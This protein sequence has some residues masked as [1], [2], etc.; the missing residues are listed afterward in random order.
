[1]TVLYLNSTIET[2]A[3]VKDP[4]FMIDATTESTAIPALKFKSSQSWPAWT[5]RPT[6][7]MRNECRINDRNKYNVNLRQYTCSFPTCQFDSHHSHI[8]LNDIF[9]NR[10]NC[11][12]SIYKPHKIVS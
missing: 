3:A 4:L 10:K 12:Y 7:L 5:T 8:G 2:D 1:M 6:S 11:Y 9:I